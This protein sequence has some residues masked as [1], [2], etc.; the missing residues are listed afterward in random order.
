MPGPNEALQECKREEFK[1]LELLDLNMTRK[2]L[3][4]ELSNQYT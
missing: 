3:L 4:I 2:G 1:V